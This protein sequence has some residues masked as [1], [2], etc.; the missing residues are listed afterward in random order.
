MRKKAES[1]HS[2][3]GNDLKV[4]HWATSLNGSIYHLFTRPNWV[5]S[6]KQMGLCV[7]VWGGE[8]RSKLQHLVFILEIYMRV[9][10][11]SRH[12]AKIEE[13]TRDEEMGD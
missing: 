10:K 9:C 1:Y 7:C 8:S 2:L 13:T 5:P 3:E 11:I 4:S 12:K 6:Q